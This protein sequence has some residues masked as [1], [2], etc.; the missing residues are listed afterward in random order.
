MYTAGSQPP[1]CHR[2]IPHSPLWNLRDASWIFSLKLKGPLTVYNAWA[3]NI[4]L[5]FC[6]A[7]NF[8][9][10]R[11]IFT[12]S[13]PGILKTPYRHSSTLSYVWVGIYPESKFP[14][15]QTNQNNHPLPQ[16]LTLLLTSAI[17]WT[18]TCARNFS[19]QFCWMI[20]WFK[21]FTYDLFLFL[22]IWVFCCMYS[23]VPCAC[24]VPEECQIP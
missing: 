13:P 11:L 21:I 2:P 24:L 18:V 9:G 19:R 7:T 15:L 3:T 17:H 12:H 5:C 4:S 20:S 10:V 22:C 8:W 6:L 23:C 14:I 16:L 1:H